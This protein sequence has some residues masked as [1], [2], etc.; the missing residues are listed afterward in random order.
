MLVQLAWKNIWR[1]KVRSGIVIASV[2]L[3]LW[4]GSFIMAYAFGM[5]DQR[6]KDAIETEISH[7]QIHHSDY[8]ED[9][10]PQ[11]AISESP[12]LIQTLTDHS[13]VRAV[14]GRVLVFGMINSPNT[15]A[16][17]KL[18]GIDPIVENRLTKLEELITEGEY[19]NPGDRNKI[20]IGE[21]LAKKLKVKLRSKVVLTFQD[22]NKDIVA[23][24]F[25]IKGIYKS[26]N[27]GIEGLSIYTSGEDL[28]KLL[29]DGAN[30]HEMA[31]LVKDTEALEGFQSELHQ[32]YPELTIESWK[33]LSPELSLMIETM[34]Q[35]LI[36]FL[37]IILVALSF[38]IINTMLMAVL[39]RVREIGM[40]M[41][42]G[43]NKPRL[44]KMIALETIFMVMIA[45]PVG[46]L[47]A[48][49]TITYLGKYG[50]DLSSIYAEGYAQYGFKSIIYPNL[51]GEH[52]LRIMILVLITAVLSSI[53]PALTAL[54]LDPVTAIR[55][56]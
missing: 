17:A 33:E 34:D 30:Y 41:A 18:I 22:T 45:A 15:S 28:S 49:G 54:R 9:N 8:Q 31:L 27:S 25:R 19:L 46:L 36:I 20:I 6:L 14:A 50:L 39:E 32:M 51:A 43:M 5:I 48:Y 24:A 26:H 13:S 40:L 2:A 55:K 53:Y 11:F 3:G 12:Q 56:I 7:I 52:Y 16:G 23:G 10:D 38:G 42:I 4:A 47:L 29:G 44:F 21:K 1:N 37:I 35:S